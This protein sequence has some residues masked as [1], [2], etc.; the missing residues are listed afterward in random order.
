[1]GIIIIDYFLIGEASAK[2]KL[3]RLA[4]RESTIQYGYRKCGTHARVFSQSLVSGCLG[5]R[6]ETVDELPN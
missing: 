1:M 6:P 3:F 4:K 5:L 2:A